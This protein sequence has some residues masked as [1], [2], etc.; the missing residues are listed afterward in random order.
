MPTWF[1]IIAIALID[2]VFWGIICHRIKK[3]LRGIVVDHAE[4][5][6]RVYAELTRAEGGTDDEFRDVFMHDLFTD[7]L[8]KWE[9]TKTWI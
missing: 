9:E 4:F 1:W 7:M 6:A 8:D 2:G 5:T 3:R